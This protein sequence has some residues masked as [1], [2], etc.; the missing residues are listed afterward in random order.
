VPGELVDGPNQYWSEQ[1][2]PSRGQYRDLALLGLRLLGVEEPQ[3]RLDA[4]TVMVRLRAAI[5]EQALPV[6]GVPEAW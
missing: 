3:T 6:G 1:L 4:T 5:C 2:P